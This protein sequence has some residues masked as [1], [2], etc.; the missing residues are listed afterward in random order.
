MLMQLRY[1][2]VIAKSIIGMICLCFDRFMKK[3]S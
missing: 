2:L 3:Y 1:K